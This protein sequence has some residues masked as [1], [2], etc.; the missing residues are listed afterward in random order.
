MEAQ[1]WMTQSCIYT[2]DCALCS[3]SILRVSRS[4]RTAASMLLYCST[5]VPHERDRDRKAG[6]VN[7]PPLSW[8]TLVES[9]YAKT[10]IVNS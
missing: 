1:D 2:S 10:D 8:T 6:Q 7:Q 5:I 3:R 9:Y 4:I